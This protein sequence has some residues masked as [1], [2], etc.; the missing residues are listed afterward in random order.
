MADVLLDRT[1]PLGDNSGVTHPAR[2]LAS[3]NGHPRPAS[4]NQ[5]GDAS[6]HPN[7]TSPNMPTYRGCVM[8]FIERLKGLGFSSYSDYLKSPH[9]IAF[10]KEWRSAGQKMSCLLCSKGPIQLHHQTYQRLGSERL[11]D[12]VP[13]CRQHHEAIHAWLKDRQKPVEFTND[14]VA[15]LGGPHIP[16]PLTRRPNAPTRKSRQRDRRRLLKS[17]R[18]AAKFSQYIG[19]LRDQVASGIKVAPSSSR[20]ATDEE[21]A[22]VLAKLDKIGLTK[23]QH[24]R[25]REFAAK[26]D[27]KQ[28]EGLLKTVTVSRVDAAGRAF[29]R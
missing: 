20:L 23:K 27:A 3:T 22:A 2:G 19:K 18:Q 24:R 29:K 13:V 5:I 21:I 16:S 12:V 9:W 10:K 4:Q 26:R 15:A 25:S 17:S 11:G 6:Q 1:G 14:A 8:T 7:Q 28:L